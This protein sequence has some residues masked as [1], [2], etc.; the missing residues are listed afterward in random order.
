MKNVINETRFEA[1]R[2]DKG[3]KRVKRDISGK[4][5]RKMKERKRRKKVV[6]FMGIEAMWILKILEN[7]VIEIAE[8]EAAIDLLVIGAGVETGRLEEGIE[9]AGTEVEVGIETE[10][11]KVE[12]E[13]GR[14]AEAE[15][16]VGVEAE[17]EVGAEAEAG[18]GLGAEEEAGVGVGEVEAEAGSLVVEVGPERGIEG[19]IEER[20]AASPGKLLTR[21]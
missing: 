4:N 19:V 3:G 17:A 10:A 18:A 9:G 15:A 5:M 20:V 16:E 14:G 1:R 21:I 7:G 8:V 11:G 12:A 6:K 13:A 2:E